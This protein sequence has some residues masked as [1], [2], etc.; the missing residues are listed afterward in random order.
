MNTALRA[1]NHIS[2]GRT[3]WVKI[4]GSKVRLTGTD[5]RRLTPETSIRT[6]LTTASVLG[7]D[8]SSIN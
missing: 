8:K 3:T 7:T 6:A 1:E 2:A 4:L 5:T